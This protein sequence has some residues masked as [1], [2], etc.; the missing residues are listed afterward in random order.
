MEISS[1][2]KLNAT[3]SIILIYTECCFANS[4]NAECRYTECHY[5]EFRY[6][7]CSYTNCR[8]AFRSVTTFSRMTL[9]V[10]FIA[11]LAKFIYN[12]AECRQTKRGVAY[13]DVSNADNIHDTKWKNGPAY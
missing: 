11:S 1:D 8:G 5:A 12:S 9:R 4:N 3:L 2:N 13:F 7:E 6:A 10:L